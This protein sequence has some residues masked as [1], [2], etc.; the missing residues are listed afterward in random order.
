MSLAGRE[1]RP[2]AL[3]AGPVDWLRFVVVSAYLAPIG[4]F[5]LASGKIA[6]GISPRQLASFVARA[7]RRPGHATAG[8]LNGIRAEKG[9]CYVARAPWAAVSDSE[10]RSRLRLWENDRPL[11]PAHC[12]HDAVRRD[13]GGRFSHWATWI[14]FSASDNSD[15]RVN[16]RTYR[17]AEENGEDETRRG[18]Q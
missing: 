12:S 7:L 5:L 6:I 17:Y 18:A 3:R 14:Y 16:G 2:S 1:V 13:G 4:L 8:A 15:P 10:G 11:G 9:Y